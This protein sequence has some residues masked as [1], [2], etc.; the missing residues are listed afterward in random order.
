MRS[1]ELTLPGFVHDDCSAIHP[2]ALASPFFR[3]IPLSDLGLEWIHPPA[4]LAHPLD[5]GQA[6][7]LYPNLERT[8]Q[9]V[10]RK[11][12]K[13]YLRMMNPLVRDWEKIIRE[14][15]GPL[16]LPR[17]PLAMARFG[18]LALRSA[19]GLATTA[20]HGE[21]TRAL[22]AGSAAHSMMPLEGSATAAIGLME[23]V[24]AHALGFPMAKGG[25]QNIAEAL[26]SHLR[27]LG[28]TIETNREIKSLGELPP[29]CATLLDITPRQLLNIGGERLPA[30]YRRQLERFRYG[31]GVFKIDWALDGPIPWTAPGV[32]QAGTIHLGGTLEEIAAAER[33]VWNGDHPDRPFVILAHQTPFDPSRAPPGKH[34]AWAY[35]HVPSGSTMNMTRQI[36]SQVERFAPGFRDLILDRHTRNAAAMEAYNPNYVGGDINGGV[37]DLRQLFTRPVPRWVPYSTPVEGLYLCSSSTPPGGGV[38]GMCGFFA[39]RAALRRAGRNP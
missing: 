24:L 7:I 18:L 35:C 36:E 19:K 29:A 23:M 12:A 10:G 5:G 9:D 4:A 34:T 17:H 25:S 6:V 39:A 13:A 15:L 32:E 30:R 3:R 33:A 28:G 1:T 38:H 16:S 31:P 14:F 20:L 27:S 8:V 2:L 22:F 26:S 37:Q 11:E 21:K